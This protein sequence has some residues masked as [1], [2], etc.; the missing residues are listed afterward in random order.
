MSTTS[1]SAVTALSLLLAGGAAAETS[2]WST[3]TAPGAP[4][5][6]DAQP[7]TKGSWN[8]STTAGPSAPKAM[9]RPQ[10]KGPKPLAPMPPQADPVSRLTSTEITKPGEGFQIIA[11]ATG[12]DAAYIAFEQG[13]YLTAL[14][15]AEAMAARGDAAAHTL[16]GR[17]YADGLG[18]SKDEITAAR[19]YARG[20]ELG[21][22]EAAFSL[23]LQLAEGRGV[24]KDRVAA[25]QMFEKAAMKGHAFA[26]YNLALLFLNGDGKPENPYRAA[27]HMRY[28]AEQGVA[29]AQYDLAVLYQT[30]HGVDPD[31]F[32]AA[33]WMRRAAEQGMVEAEY[34]YALLLLKGLGL[35]AELP[36]APDYLRSAAEKGI[37]GAQN[38]LAHLLSD[39][40]KGDK[41]IAEAIKWRLL[42]KEGGLQD[43]ALDAT[44]AKLPAATRQSAERL[45]QEWRDRSALGMAPN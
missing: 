44:F 11:P 8:P 43:D 40:S 21:D 5:A 28:A 30:G 7:Q 35:N 12:E 2:S 24:E 20:A 17:I 18:V 36:K 31:A 16:I 25:G 33:R 13:Q 42:A 3:R 1:R 19:W 9:A 29:A 41:Q 38:R 39:G 26:N 15:L 14:S 4:S 37:A 34:D 27:Q 10:P 6:T 22:I 23:G 32:E 45:A